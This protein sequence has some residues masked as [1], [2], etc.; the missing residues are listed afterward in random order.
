MSVDRGFYSE[1][2]R[3]AA[4]QSRSATGAVYNSSN[5]VFSILGRITEAPDGKFYADNNIENPVVLVWEGSQLKAFTTTQQFTNGIMALTDKERKDLANR[6][7]KIPGFKVSANRASGD[8]ESAALFIANQNT[9]A[10]LAMLQA[11][12]QSGQTF[13]PISFEDTLTEAATG[14]GGTA[15]TRQVSYASVSR[16][17]SAAILEGFYAEALG[18]RPNE[19]EVNKFYKQLQ[20]AA[21]KKPTVTTQTTTG[22]TTTSRTQAGFTQS[23]AELMARETAESTRGA[24]GYLMSTKYFDAFLNA[25]ESRA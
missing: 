24:S 3:T 5:S 11:S 8:L 22:Q 15:T 4:A 25:I 13:K 1:V 6:I 16:E 9:K 19:D 18:R 12:Q 17:E 20:A 7:N 23:D 14:G 2:E 21:N 10:N